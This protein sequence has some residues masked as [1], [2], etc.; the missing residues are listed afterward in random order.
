LAQRRQ[1]LSVDVDAALG[2][3]VLAPDLVEL[4]D[5]PCDLT[6]LALGVVHVRRGSPLEPLQEPGK[7]PELAIEL[8]VEGLDAL[9]ALQ[10]LEHGL[11]DDGIAILPGEVAARAV[12]ANDRL[13][14]ALEAGED[15]VR[16]R[17]EAAADV[18][19]LAVAHEEVAG[20]GHEL[21][22]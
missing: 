18:A 5:G 19:P 9:L 15:A 14:L 4:I 21:R 10:H 16:R 2:L 7:L 13:V 12:A 11:L 22:E 1:E 17:A 8:G 3:A 20:A 6:R